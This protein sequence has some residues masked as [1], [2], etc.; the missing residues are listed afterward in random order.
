MVKEIYA[1][2]NT[3]ESKESLAQGESLI[4]TRKLDTSVFTIAD[5]LVQA[6][7]TRTFFG[8]ICIELN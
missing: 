5:G 3:A 6:I 4:Q 7:L 8:G 2:A 1:L